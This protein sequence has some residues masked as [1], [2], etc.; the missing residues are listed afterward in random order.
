L[1]CHAQSATV[2]KLAAAGGWKWS[3]VTWGRPGA[4]LGVFLLALFDDERDRAVTLVEL[5][6]EVEPPAPYS[7]GGWL[8]HLARVLGDPQAG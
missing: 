2:G 8:A 6:M 7:P 1:E 3:Q 5:G 4:W